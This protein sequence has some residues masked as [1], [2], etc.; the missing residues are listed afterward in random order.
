[1]LL[2][3]FFFNIPDSR[4]FLISRLHVSGCLIQLGV[5]CYSFLLL[6]GVLG[7]GFSAVV[8]CCSDF[9]IPRHFVGILFSS[10]AIIPVGTVR[11]GFLSG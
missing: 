5:L 9:S 2:F 7:E 11:C 1:M 6:H 10:G 3:F 8:Q 4:C